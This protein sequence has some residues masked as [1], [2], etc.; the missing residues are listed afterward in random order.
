MFTGILKAK[1]PVTDVQEKE[2]LKT[3]ALV[4][5][6]KLRWGLRRGASVSIDGVCMT[7]TNKRGSKVYFDAMDETLTKTTLGDVKD[8]DT[9]NIER[10]FKVGDEVGGHI[11]SGHVTGK[12]TIAKI[13]TPPGNHIIWF[14][15]PESQMKYVMPKGFIAL[16]GASLTVVD[17]QGST[18]SV[19]LIP[20]TLAI[21][22]FGDLEEGDEVNYEIDSRTQAYVDTVL[23]VQL[24]QEQPKRLSDLKT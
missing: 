2:G 15:I 17:V 12:A 19:Y 13:E 6:W 9:V 21:T 18:F 8:G 22:T 3:F 20:E 16:N 10:S 11:V 7:V 23:A 14:E 5:P 24:E 1:V 4:M